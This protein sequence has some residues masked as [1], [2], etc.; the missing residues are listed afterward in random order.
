MTCATITAPHVSRLGATSWLSG[1]VQDCRGGKTC[2]LHQRGSHLQT[3]WRSHMVCISR[4]DAP[5]NPLIRLALAAAVGAREAQSAHSRARES[6]VFFRGL[7]QPR[8]ARCVQARSQYWPFP[9]DVQ[10]VPSRHP[11]AEATQ[12]PPLPPHRC[13]LATR[14]QRSQMKRP[15]WFARSRTNSG[16]HRCFCIGLRRPRARYTSHREGLEVGADLVVP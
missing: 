2:M 12:N 8:C 3:C 4:G 15:P 1:D 14:W 13:C 11:K 10:D 16:R 7:W 5:R 9:D 6:R